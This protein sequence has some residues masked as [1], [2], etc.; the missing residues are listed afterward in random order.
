MLIVIIAHTFSVN[1]KLKPNMMI[2]MSGIGYNEE[3]ILLFIMLKIG[4]KKV[5]N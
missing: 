1:F 5:I 4:M 3:Y 2:F